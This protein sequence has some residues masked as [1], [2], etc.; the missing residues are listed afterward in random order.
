MGERVV[1]LRHKNF[2]RSLLKPKIKLKGCLGVVLFY[3]I[4]IFSCVGRS[5]CY[6]KGSLGTIVHL[7]ENL[8]WGTSRSSVLY[9]SETSQHRKIYIKTEST[10]V[11]GPTNKSAASILGQVHLYL[12]YLGFLFQTFANLLP[13]SFVVSVL[14]K[15]VIH[16]FASICRVLHETR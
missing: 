9:Y 14:S 5:E 11:L 12:L 10:N 1:F 6:K 16:N 13:F 2:W 3:F 4:F 8:F 15:K 7:V